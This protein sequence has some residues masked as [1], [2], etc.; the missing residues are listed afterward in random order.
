M[1]NT[2]IDSEC[3]LHAI[4]AA[5]DFIVGTTAQKQVRVKIKAIISNN[6]FVSSLTKCLAILSP[7]DL[8]I[9]KYQS[10][11]VPVSEFLPDFNSLPAASTSLKRD[12]GLI[13]N[14][15]LIMVVYPQ[16]HSQF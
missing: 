16:D 7:I 1:C 10:D 8:L 2:I 4:V 3:A 11:S 9:M 5:R 14:S 15:E 12:G 13:S 6:E